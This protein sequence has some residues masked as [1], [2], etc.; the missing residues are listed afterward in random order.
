MRRPHLIVAIVLLSACAAEQEVRTQD[1]EQAVRDY[2][3]VRGLEEVDKLR[4][5]SA[6]R[7]EEIEAHFVIY[8]TRRHAFLI[9]FFRACYELSGSVVVADERRESNTIRARFDT[10]RGCRIDKIFALTEADVAELKS[11]GEIAGSR[12]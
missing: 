5:G 1:E 9:E 11:L 8:K 4:S 3:A 12:N 2:I 10:L 7:W 6:D